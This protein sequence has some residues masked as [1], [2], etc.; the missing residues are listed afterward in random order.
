MFE[1]E[2]E[3]LPEELR[4]NLDALSETL[5]SK[6]ERESVRERVSKNRRRGRVDEREERKR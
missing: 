3:K 5:T 4:P 1:V 2:E 6:R